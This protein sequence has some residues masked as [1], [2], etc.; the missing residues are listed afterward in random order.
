M[1][2]TTL[3]KRYPMGLA[4]TAMNLDDFKHLS[5]Y[6]KNDIGLL[7]ATPIVTDNKSWQVGDY[8]STQ[9]FL[10]LCRKHRVTPHSIHSFYI[11]EIGHDM[12]D[13]DPEVRKKA[14]ELNMEMF[15]AAVEIKASYV[16]V[17]LFNERV[18]RTPGEALFYAKETL[19]KLLPEAEK[20]GVSIAVENLYYDWTITQI[21][22]LLDE[23][24]HPLLGICLDVGHAA[25]Y[26][27]AHEELALCGDRLL[28]FHIHDNWFKDDDHLLPFRGKID[29]PAFCSALL[30]NG[31][32][33]PL[34]YESFAREENESVD[35]FIDACHASY[36]KLLELL[37][38]TAS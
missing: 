7:E 14:I 20:T 4:T 17:H 21:N 23:I 29:W 1:D 13:A 12:T 22:H 31:Y 8:Q 11:A 33:G 9:S 10:A 36:L 5:Q 37:S 30:K 19:K 2:L 35:E 34:I 32:Q 26:S 16:V 38:V 18:K 3:K 6:E 25:L 27:T 24:N 28:G 15:A